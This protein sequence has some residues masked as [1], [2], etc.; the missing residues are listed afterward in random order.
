MDKTHTLRIGGTSF[1]ILSEESDAYIRSLERQVNSM[2][3]SAQLKGATSQKAALF[4]CMELCDMLRKKEMELDTLNN[5]LSEY[6]SL[7]SENKK[8]SCDDIFFPDKDQI[9]FF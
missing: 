9:S 5:Q 6:K 2:L 8:K 7:K 4:V 3:E 1:S